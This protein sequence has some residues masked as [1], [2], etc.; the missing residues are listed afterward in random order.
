MIVGDIMTNDDALWFCLLRRRSLVV[1]QD[2]TMNV[3]YM[4][5][6]SII[7]DLFHFSPTFENCD[8]VVVMIDPLVQPTVSPG[9]S[10]ASPASHSATACVLLRLGHDLRA[11]VAALLT[12]RGCGGWGKSVCK[13]KGTMRTASLLLLYSHNKR[14]M[15]RAFR[16][17]EVGNT[18]QPASH[19]SRRHKA[20]RQREGT[21]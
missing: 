10:P 17:L 21:S 11:Q 1:G 12:N 4:H 8:G 14:T 3:R 19:P 2:R 6:W 16:G 7:V 20:R 13:G 15:S 18:S 9:I 5:N